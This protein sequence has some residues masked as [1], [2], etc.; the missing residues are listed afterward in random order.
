MNSELYK[1]AWQK[2]S[3]GDRQAA[4]DLYAEDATIESLGKSSTGQQVRT[5]NEHFSWCDSN[6]LQVL[7]MR[8]LSAN[9]S[10][11]VWA[12][13]FTADGMDEVM[14][15]L[16]HETIENGKITQSVWCRAPAP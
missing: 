4:K 10:H 12:N 16:G 7:E 15:A 13:R 6:N 5:K 3:S 8:L 14:A 1:S 11:M 9:D 2:W